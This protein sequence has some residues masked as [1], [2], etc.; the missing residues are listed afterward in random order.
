MTYKE[1]IRDDLEHLDDGIMSAVIECCKEL[2]CDVVF[3]HKWDK[4]TVLEYLDKALAQ[5]D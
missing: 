3:L 2:F 4:D 1:K 5:Y